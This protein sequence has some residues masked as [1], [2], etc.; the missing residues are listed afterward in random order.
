MS[1]GEFLSSQSPEELWQALPNSVVKVGNST[2]D[3]V[4]GIHFYTLNRFD[5]TRTIFDSL[6]IP[7]HCN[8]QIP[9]A[10]VRPAVATFRGQRI[11]SGLR[12][13]RATVAKNP[14]W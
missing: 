2:D 1:T 3:Q 12:C 10:Q 13:I 11:V 4:A 5:A 14:V 7:R 8:T 6:G 9:I